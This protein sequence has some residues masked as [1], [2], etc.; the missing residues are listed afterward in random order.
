VRDIAPILGFCLFFQTIGEN[1][2]KLV[3]Q[4]FVVGLESGL[5]H[6]NQNAELYDMKGDVR[7][8]RKPVFEVRNAKTLLF[9]DLRRRTAQL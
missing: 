3:T 5:K 6:L 1:V 4:L 2:R 7:C 9:K 8:I